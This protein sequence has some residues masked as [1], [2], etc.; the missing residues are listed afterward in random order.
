MADRAWR[1]AIQNPN[2]F[3][4]LVPLC[5]GGD[6]PYAKKIKHLP[7]WA[8]H[9][10]QDD[11]I[12]VSESQQMV[13]ALHSAGNEARFTVYPDAKHDAWTE[14]YRNEELFRW[15]LGQQNNR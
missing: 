9:G 14:T 13:D 11:L 10:R 3:A 2:R 15:M 5:G 8:F 1:L 7:V 4:C 6:P 12:P